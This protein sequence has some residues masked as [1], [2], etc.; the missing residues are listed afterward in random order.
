M[1]RRT[2]R[3]VAATMAA[4]A[5]AIYFLIGFQVVAV[6]DDVGA[7]AAF[8]LPAAIAFGLA[9]VALVLVDNRVLWAVG[10]VLQALIIVMYFGVAGQRTPPFEFWGLLIRVVQAAMLVALV[11]LA[12]RPKVAR[13]GGRP[14][15]A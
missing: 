11:I 10:A 13:V 1:D 6:I 9:A 7:Q 12:I 8:G 3:Y 4:T 14:A 2:I 5:S 15:T